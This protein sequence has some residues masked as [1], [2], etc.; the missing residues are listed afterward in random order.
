MRRSAGTSGGSSS[1]SVSSRGKLCASIIVVLMI[2]SFVV[3]IPPMKAKQYLATDNGNVAEVQRILAAHQRQQVLDD[4]E[5]GALNRPDQ[6][7]PE[8]LPGGAA[9][10]DTAGI[11]AAPRSA[12]GASGARRKIDL[13]IYIVFHKTL[14]RENYAGIRWNDIAFPLT[15]ETADKT[16]T[17]NTASIVSA[18]AS[19]GGA[20]RTTI[21]FVATNKRL[22]KTYPQEL[23]RGRLINEWE[24][25]G[26]DTRIGSVMNEYG[27]MNSIFSSQLTQHAGNI[28]NVAGRGSNP[29][30]IA[31]DA[32]GDGVQEWIGLFQYDM[33]IDQK[34]L[35]LIRRRIRSRTQAAITSLAVTNSRGELVARP[36]TSTSHGGHF[37][38]H[39]CI[40][41]GVSYPTRYL[42]HNALGRALVDE[43]NNFYGSS[44]TLD[45]MP[46]V[47]ILDAFVVPTIVFNHFAPFLESVMLR[48]IRN[49]AHFPAKPGRQALTSVS[50]PQSAGGGSSTGNISASQKAIIEHGLDVMEAAQAVALGLE[51]LFVQVQLPLRHKSWDSQS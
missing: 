41:Y 34:L 30:L 47:A 49:P 16:T 3:T 20:N 6:I 33:R 7:I 11:E 40:F 8:E 37:R 35:Q 48:V 25:P 9:G 22:R 43:Y 10:G 51:T 27:A 21:L 50:S 32:D 39:C 5:I 23:V 44:F 31:A 28:A 14:H 15:S 42:L 36:A 4:D 17:L 46:P 19:P 26:H 12:G 2:V 45:D 1:T 29:R 38:L 24:L 18:L 13:T